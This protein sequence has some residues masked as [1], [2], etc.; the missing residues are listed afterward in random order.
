MVKSD[1]DESVDLKQQIENYK[2]LL[3]DPNF[4]KL[5]TELQKPNIFSILG[6]G[7]M[8]IRHSNFLAW[9]LDPNASHGLGNRFL[10]RVLRDLAILENKLDIFDINKLSF[11]NVEV[12]RE[13][14]IKDGSIDILIVFRDKEDKL[15]ICIENKID[16]IDSDGQ[17]DNYKEYI[18]SAYDGYKK[19]FVYLTI[20]GE[21]PK[22]CNEEGWHTYSYEKNIIKH[23][24]NTQEATIN[25]TVKTY[26]SDYLST[27]KTEIMGTQSDAKK[28]AEVIY[29]EHKEI[30]KFVYEN[31]GNEQ[32]KPIW[33][34]SSPWVVDFALRLIK[35]IKETD[36]TNEYDLGYNKTAITVKQ[37]KRTQ[38]RY[39]NIYSIYRRAEPACAMDFDLLKPQNNKT[40]IIIDS[41][42]NFLSNVKADKDKLNWNKVSP[43]SINFIN[44]LSD[45]ELKKIQETSFDVV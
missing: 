1:N 15:V 20:F 3:H 8:E 25:S 2:K 12:N 39:Y 13:Y 23:I 33:D 16:A 31:I 24:E 44:E 4:E 19:V 42:D 36:S 10:I 32:F 28:L 9:L 30:F 37:K 7:R 21:S 41:I 22:K 5:E 35:L 6:I 17:L 14:K 27:L 43:F 38:N 34:E 26:I 29:T 11:S 45:E 18:D 40:Q